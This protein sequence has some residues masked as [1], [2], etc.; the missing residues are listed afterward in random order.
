MCIRVNI[1]VCI[2]I[3]VHLA[4]S[5]V[6][7]RVAECVHGC[8]S[9]SVPGVYPAGMGWDIAQAVEHS[10]VKV[11]ILLNGRSILHGGCM[12]SLDYF[13][14]QPVVHNRSIRGCGMCC[15]V[16]GKVHIKDP[17]LLIRKSSLCGDSKF[18]LQKYVTMT[19]CLTSN[20]R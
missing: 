7:E 18:P 1:H 16:C 4:A 13:P 14:F 15:P 6:P 10:A 5:W 8:L 11:G 19:I 12:C 20:S 3:Q 2:Q 9:R 17:L